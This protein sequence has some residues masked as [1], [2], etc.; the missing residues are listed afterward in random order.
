VHVI[1]VLL[2]VL[3]LAEEIRRIGEAG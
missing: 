1:T 3:V 2:F